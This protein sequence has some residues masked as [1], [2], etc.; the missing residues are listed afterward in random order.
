MQ[1]ILH[2]FATLTTKSSDWKRTPRLAFLPSHHISKQLDSP[3]TH[4]PHPHAVADLSVPTPSYPFLLSLRI[5]MYPHVSWCFLLNFLDRYWTKGIKTG[6][7]GHILT[8]WQHNTI[9]TTMRCRAKDSSSVGK[10]K[11]ALLATCFLGICNS[12][13]SLLLER[14]HLISA[15]RLLQD[16]IRTGSGEDM[17]L[18]LKMKFEKICFKTWSSGDHRLL[19][20]E[21]NKSL[22]RALFEGPQHYYVTIFSNLNCYTN[23]ASFQVHSEDSR[24]V[25]LRQRGNVSQPQKQ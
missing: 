17:C 8:A 3:W 18:D 2:T 6:L 12:W 9:T 10:D 11:A 13:L 25:T 15:V 16:K 20:S 22:W 24:C 7:C 5:L 14:V 4:I 19:R 21:F 1:P 23:S